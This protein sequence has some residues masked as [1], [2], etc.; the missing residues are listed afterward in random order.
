MALPFLFP[1]QAVNNARALQTRADICSLNEL[2]AAF[3]RGSDKNRGRDPE[4]SPQATFA[5]PRCGEAPLQTLR[6]ANPRSVR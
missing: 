2:P 3:W 6:V 5:P 1:E 4:V